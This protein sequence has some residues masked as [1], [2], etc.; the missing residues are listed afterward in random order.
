MQQS[1]LTNEELGRE[2]TSDDRYTPP[3]VIRCLEKMWPRGIDLDP[4]WSPLSLVLAKRT[5]TVEDDGLDAPWWSADK[6][7]SMAVF[8]NPPWSD[9]GPWIR[10]A[11]KAAKMRSDV[12]F[13]CKLDT[14]TKWWGQHAWD[15]GQICFPGRLR[16]LLPDGSR[17]GTP[18]FE[19]AILHFGGQ[20]K[21]FRRS[22]SELGKVLDL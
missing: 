18:T 13:L 5:F 21:R 1:L 16:F 2:P 19:T 7:Y 12:V 10:R 4:C 17:M 14:S 6:R 9:V 22:F 20:R 3:E 8:V 11:K 15:A